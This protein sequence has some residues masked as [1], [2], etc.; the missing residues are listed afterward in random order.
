MFKLIVFLFAVTNGVAAE[1]PSG[2]LM[3]KVSFETEKSCMEYLNTEEGKKAGIIID[4]II[5]AAKGKL[6]AKF[7]CMSDGPLKKDD[8]I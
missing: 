7:V 4:E 8:S 5:E 3:N 2:R 1:H 6:T